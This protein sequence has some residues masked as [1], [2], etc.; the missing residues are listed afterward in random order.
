MWLTRGMLAAG[1]LAILYHAFHLHSGPKTPSFLRFRAGAPVLRT[2]HL[3][4]RACLSPD[5]GADAHVKLYLTNLSPLR[6]SNLRLE[7]HLDGAPPLNAPAPIS[8][9]PPAVAAN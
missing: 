9:L 2:R 5:G 7:A 4:V 6:L 8:M 1:L 3:E